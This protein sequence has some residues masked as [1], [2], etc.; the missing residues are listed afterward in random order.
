MKN[1]QHAYKIYKKRI[2]IS[3]KKFN[4]VADWIKNKNAAK[5]RYK[6]ILFP[7]SNVESIYKDIKYVTVVLL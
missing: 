6:D 1:E 7:H 2:L 3:E 5:Y 4:G